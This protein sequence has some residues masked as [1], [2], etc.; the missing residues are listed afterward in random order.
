MSNSMNKKF[1]V[2]L[3]LRN[4]DRLASYGEFLT[5]E[6]FRVTTAATALECWAELKCER[7]DVLILDLELPWGG[8]DG[9]LA[10]LDEKPETRGI[11]AIMLAGGKVLVSRELVT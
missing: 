1:H 5:H 9:V 10:R 8:G 2:L 11:P 6:G 4:S 3:A 7:P